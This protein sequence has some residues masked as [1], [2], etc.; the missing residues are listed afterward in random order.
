VSNLLAGTA[1]ALALGVD[2]RAIAE[3]IARFRGAPGRLERITDG[4][5]Y[6]VLVDYAHNTGGLECVLST[7]RRLAGGRLIVVFGCGGDRDPSKR[8]LMGR[9]AARHADVAFLTSDNSRSER[10]EDIIRSILGG[11]PR[12]AAH[13]V[14]P[15]R[16]QAIRQAIAMARDGDLVLIAGKGHETY[17]EIDGIRYPFDDREEARRAIGSRRRAP[18]GV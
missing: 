18:V 11:M 3:G 7:L 13:V 2:L 4:Q 14:E 8:P 17:Q 5:P 6:T 1:C 12:G 15:D 9:A 10:S 16:R